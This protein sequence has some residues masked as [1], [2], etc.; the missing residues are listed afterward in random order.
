MRTDLP[1]SVGPLLIVAAL[2]VLA[3][4]AWLGVTTAAGKDDTKLA[5]EL[6]AL[7]DAYVAAQRAGVP[8]APGRFPVPVVDGRVI[9]DAT[10]SA[11]VG[12]L[13]ADLEA[14]G[15]QH[16]ASA[17]RIVSGQLPI[18]AIGALSAL[19]SLRFARAAMAATRGGA[20]GNP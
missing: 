7:Y 12:A 16:I 5:P 11:D 20:R 15:M 2:L 18:S 1:T 9:I 6:W 3:A 19:S 17:G 14:L 13:Q 8:F 4:G 10:A